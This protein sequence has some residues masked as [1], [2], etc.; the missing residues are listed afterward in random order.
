MP[1][2][3]QL[4]LLTTLLVGAVLLGTRLYYSEV[5]GRAPLKVTQWDALA[6]YAYLPSLFIHHDLARMGWIEGIDSTYQVVGTG[7]LYQMLPVEDSPLAA[8]G[9]R[10]DKVLIGMSIVELPFFAIGHL[11]AWIGGHPQDGFSPP[12]QWSIGLAPVVYCILGLF[13]LRRTLLRWFKDSSVAVVLLLVPLA[14]N[15]IQYISVDN[16]QTHGFLFALYC[17]Q[18]DLTHRW[19]VRPS[20]RTLVTIGCVVVLAAL[21]RPTDVLMFLIPLLW[22]TH[23]PEAAR[24]KWAQVRAHRKDL[25]WVIGACLLLGFPQL[26]YWKHASGHWFFDIGSKWDFL[27]PHWRVLIGWEKGWF[28]YTPI[29]V[30]F[31]L[32]QLRMRDR[33]WRRSVAWFMGLTIWVVIA[34]HDWRYGGSYSARALMQCL[35]VLALPFA[36]LVERALATR[37]RW[38]FLALCGY[39][40]VV[41]MWQVRQYNNGVIKY[42]GMTREEYL[43]VYLR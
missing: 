43:R 34:W 8:Q 19:H 28:I 6:Y 17:L 23:T 21:I 38:P 4:S 1:G 2:A 42:D 40:L 24:A 27:S 16:A 22:N 9:N 36:D 3:R 31:M 30:V 41:N 11:A 39:L 32:A 35:P 29:T 13:L 12:Y 5:G 18:L 37:W 7:G 10:V 15:A 14:T 33:P 26:L 20:R 25:P